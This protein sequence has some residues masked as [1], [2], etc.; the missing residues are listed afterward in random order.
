MTK[1]TDVARQKVF[2]DVGTD[3][4]AAGTTQGTATTMTGDH[5]RVTSATAGSAQG[6]ILK[7][8]NA[9][10]P[11]TVSNQTAVDIVVYP[12]VGAQLN[13]YTA[14]AGITIPAYKAAIFLFTSSTNITVIAG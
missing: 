3:I 7:A 12:P 4:A 5:N 10:S 13:G 11:R 1:L 2:G 6:V 9:L 14:N 8:G